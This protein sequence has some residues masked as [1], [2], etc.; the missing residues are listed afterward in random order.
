MTFNIGNQ[1]GGIIN[2]VAG[3]QTIHGD[4]RGELVTSREA[5]QAAR[6]LR[7]A[8]DHTDLPDDAT[9]RRKAQDI[10]AEMRS[11]APDKSKV[12]RYLD[13]IARAIATA[14]GW[15][16]AGAA[17]LGPVRILATWLGHLGIPILGLLPAL[18]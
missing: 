13:G 14:G 16:R 2:N 7:E 1:S 18:A 3:D 4:Q 10:D 5:Q 12:A 6:D 15:A 8:V 9:A 17:I 11:G